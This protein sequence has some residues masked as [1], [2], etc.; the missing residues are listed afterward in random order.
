[1]TVVIVSAPKLGRAALAAESG[2]VDED[3]CP[4]CCSAEIAAAATA[5][6]EGVIDH[7]AVAMRMAYGAPGVDDES[8]RET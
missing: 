4:G 3:T 8:E 7:K 2:T 6:L 1:M 5:R